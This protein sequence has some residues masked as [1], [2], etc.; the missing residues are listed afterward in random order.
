MESVVAVMAERI[1][2]SSLYN[3]RCPHCE[4]DVS[5]KYGRIHTGKQRYLCLMCGRQ[6]T[7]GAMRTEWKDKPHCPVCGRIMHVYK[8]DG[9]ILRFR[10]SG[11]PGCRIYTKQILEKGAA[12]ELLHA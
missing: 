9:H 1:K 7:I 11:Y 10:C 2:K 6:F 12:N 8:R 5:Y 3:I 4:A